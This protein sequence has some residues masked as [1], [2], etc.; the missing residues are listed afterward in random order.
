MCL[1]SCHPETKYLKRRRYSPSF[2]PTIALGI[3][4]G[5][6]AGLVTEILGDVDVRVYS[7]GLSLAFLNVL[8]GEEVKDIAGELSVDM[9][10]RGPVGQ[11]VP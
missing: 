3:C 9:T 11:P 6:N 2:G 10:L 1:P 5:R 7:T 8:S 4:P